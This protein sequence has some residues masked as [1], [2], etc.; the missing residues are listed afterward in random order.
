MGDHYLMFLSC[1]F[2]L[3]TWLIIY[4]IVLYI[5]VELNN[6]E[7][8]I[9]T[10]LNKYHLT[11]VEQFYLDMIGPTLNSEQLAN[12]SS[13]NVGGTGLV[14]D[15]AFRSHVSNSH[16]GRTYSDATNKLHQA[17]MT[18]IVMSAET[19]AKMSDNNA[20]VTVFIMDT[21]TKS[22]T[23]FSTKSAACLHL[24]VSLRTITRWSADCNQSHFIKA[25][26]KSVRVSFIPFK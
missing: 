17:N 25:T 15:Q 2:Y 20:G 11:L 21:D 4:Y 8:D 10:L 3:I 19:R 23:M 24:S 12:A 7:R 13:Y 6:D 5:S 18:G 14:R 22:V 16:L 9:L 26:G 1:V